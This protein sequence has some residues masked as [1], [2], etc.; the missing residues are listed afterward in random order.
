[1]FTN[2]L[3]KMIERTHLS[4]CPQIFQDL[5]LKKVSEYKMGSVF[6]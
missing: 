3:F 1:M 6:Q 2:L 4:Q 5:N